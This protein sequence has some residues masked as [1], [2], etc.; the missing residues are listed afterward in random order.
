MTTTTKNVD[1]FTDVARFRAD[2]PVTTN[3][4]DIDGHDVTA[5]L[6]DHVDNQ[7]EP[8]EL[9]A[10]YDAPIEVTVTGVNPATG[11]THSLDCCVRCALFAVAET[12]STERTTV[13]VARV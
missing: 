3:P 13:E 2:W 5:A 11:T 6:V 8:C 1:Y 9:C 12:L 10:E 4:F 7:G